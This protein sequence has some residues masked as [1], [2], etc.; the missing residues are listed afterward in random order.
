MI[1]YLYVKQQPVSGLKYFGRTIRKDP[2]K[3]KG[4]GTYWV[5]HYKKY[6]SNSIKTLEIWGFDSQELCSEFALKFSEENNIVESEEWANQ[7]P[8]NGESHFSGLKFTDDHKNK[9]SKSN[10]GKKKSLETRDKI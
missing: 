8:E 10:M 2:F 5:N 6:G 7:I 9:I 3:Y 4:S 1:I